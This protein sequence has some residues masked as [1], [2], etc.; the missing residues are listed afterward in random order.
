M[1]FLE[2]F[3]IVAAVGLPLGLVAVSNLLLAWSGESGTLLLPCTGRLR[4]G[5]ASPEEPKPAAPGEIR[6][7]FSALRRFRLARARPHA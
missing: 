4:M 3:V 6:S 2:D 5:L 7:A 1:E